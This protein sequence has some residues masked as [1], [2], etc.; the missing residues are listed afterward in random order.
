MADNLG[1]LAA[2]LAKA[3]AAF[4]EITRDKE[5]TV[6]SD[7]GSYKFKYAPLEKIIEKVRKPL[8]DNGLAFTQLLD[9]DA[10]G[11]PALVSM[12]LHADGGVLTARTP[13]P[14]AEGQKVQQFGST[15]TYLRRYALQAMLGIAAEEDDDG[16]AASGN[17]ATFKA[18]RPA[19]ER[20]ERPVSDL[21]GTAQ[22]GEAP[23][24]FQLREEPE[25]WALSFKLMDGRKG[26]RVVARDDLAQALA[27]VK[28]DVIGQRVT[29]WGVMGSESFEKGG[30]TI[31]YNV[32]ELSR[33]ETPT[34]TLPMDTAKA[35]L[36]VAAGLTPPESPQTPDSGAKCGAKGPDSIPGGAI[37]NLAKG[38]AGSHK[39]VA[40]D[41]HTLAGWAQ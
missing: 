12:L 26:F 4:P 3:Q 2:A 32:I 20:L 14:Y 40:T 24:D 33:I 41:G 23:A 37:C 28:D 36:P 10:E 13:I 8:A 19:P 6:T 5:V 15:I 16:N 29:C 39:E 21:I 7:K 35:D 11:L 34:I 27:L 18:P 30:T 31:R 22:I 38:H 17:R 25:G 1:A 9:S